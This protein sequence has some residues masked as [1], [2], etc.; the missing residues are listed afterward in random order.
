[1][2][3]YTE[4]TIIGWALQRTV[5]PNSGSDAITTGSGWVPGHFMNLPELMLA[6]MPSL[7]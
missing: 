4:K 2:N 7:D 1:M 5:R 6:M 3:G